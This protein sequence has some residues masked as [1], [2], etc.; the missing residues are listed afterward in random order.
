MRVFMYLLAAGAL[1][2]VQGAAA[3]MQP[4]RAE[5]VLRLGTAVN[6][7]RVGT[8]TQDLTLDCDAWH[9]KR[10]V[11]GEVPISATWKFELTSML[12]SDEGRS[13]NDLH[14]RVLQVQNGAERE[15]RGTVQRA[16]GELLAR[17]LSPDGSANRVLPT[18]TRM[19]VASIDYV[20][21]RLRL[22]LASF[23]TLSFDAQGSGEVFRVDVAQIENS[24]LRR[25]LPSDEQVGMPGRSWPLRMSFVRDN[26]DKP[27]FTLT[28]RLSEEGILDYV[29]VDAKMVALS[30]DLKALKMY[31]TP[32]CQQIE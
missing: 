17:S 27:L 10:D 4:H 29:T 12:V 16:D 21:D 9:L 28:A 30:A 6:A 5:Y 25:R 13:G 14:Y 26:S 7:P 18:L 24:A 19:P 23:S 15:V 32:N 2:F 8:A 20:V 22:G 11:K 31:P 3:Q 1:F